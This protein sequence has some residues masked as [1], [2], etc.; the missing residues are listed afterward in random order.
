MLKIQKQETLKRLI[1]EIRIW[2]SE[3]LTQ[4]QENHSEPGITVKIRVPKQKHDIGLAEH[5]SF[6][7]LKL[8]IKTILGVSAIIVTL[9][10]FYYTTQMR[11]DR[12]EASVGQNSSSEELK[13]LKKQIQQLNKRVKK[14]ENKWNNLISRD[15]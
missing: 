6:M 15:M 2:K 5:G 11:L 9:A 1:L 10:G 3:S 4:K 12:L 14:L 8:D 13:S 7:Q